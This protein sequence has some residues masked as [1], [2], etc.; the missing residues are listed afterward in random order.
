MKQLYF[1][2]LFISISLI[3]TGQTDFRFAD[4]TA[5]WNVLETWYGWCPC[6]SYSTDVCTVGSDTSLN[7]VNYQTILGGTIF[8]NSGVTFIREDSLG[9]VY[10]LSVNDP[11]EEL[12]YDFSKQTGDTFSVGNGYGGLAIVCHVDSVSFITMGNTRKVLYITYNM[13]NWKEDIWIEGIGSIY[14]H[15]LYPGVDHTIVDGSSYSLLCYFENGTLMYHDTA[16]NN[17]VIDTTIYLGINDILQQQAQL[18]PNPVTQS[19]F[20]V[21]LSETPKPNTAF[22]LY[23]AVGRLVMREELN[24]INQI[25]YANGLTSGLYTYMITVADEKSMG[26][27]IILR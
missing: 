3:S 14:S 18:S 9:K 2:I 17:C 23:D 24:S 22:M 13:D 4:S 21:T 19:Q 20:T 16:F 7:G 10:R 11:S 8:N 15:I 27:V 25:I 1:F 26:K 6:I 5:Q 12:I